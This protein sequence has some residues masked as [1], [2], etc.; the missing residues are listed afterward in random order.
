MSCDVVFIFL[1]IIKILYVF[2]YADTPSEFITLKYN[3][4]KALEIRTHYTRIH[5]T[6]QVVRII[7]K[8]VRTTYS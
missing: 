2:K 5:I 7:Y 4:S 1:N 6:Y 3:F 8:V